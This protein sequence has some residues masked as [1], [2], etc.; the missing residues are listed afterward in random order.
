MIR[1][2]ENVIFRYYLTTLI[3][4]LVLFKRKIPKAMQDR[5]KEIVDEVRY[6]P[7]SKKDERY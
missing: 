4:I 2:I 5:M 1:Y 6:T 7:I 3:F